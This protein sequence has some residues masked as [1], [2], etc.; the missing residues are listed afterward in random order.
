[1]L[2]IL[3]GSETTDF[4]RIAMRDE[5]PFQYVDEFSK[6]LVRSPANV[7]AKARQAFARKQN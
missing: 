1:M 3:Q 4:N 2:R 6:M 7:I 5:C